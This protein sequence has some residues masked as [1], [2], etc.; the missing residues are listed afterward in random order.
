[1][2]HGAPL[3][4]SALLP[5]ACSLRRRKEGLSSKRD[6]YVH[7]YS[8]ITACSY[9]VLLQVRA[10]HAIQVVY[11]VLRSTERLTICSVC[12]N[13]IHLTTS[14]ILRPTPYRHHQCT[15]EHGP[16]N[17]QLGA[18]AFNTTLLLGLP[19]PTRRLIPTS[20]SHCH[21]FVRCSVRGVFECSGV[22][23]A[24]R[25]WLTESRWIRRIEQSTRGKL[26]K[27]F[28]SF[29]SS[30]GRCMLFRPIENQSNPIG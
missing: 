13:V 25:G 20:A 11:G 19:Q 21:Q 23:G 7:M 6:G 10:G 18:T 29:C 1:M 17:G 27:T 4:K 15:L 5:R 16:S 14:S 2:H 8:G 28:R 12:A 22:S 26:V 3:I 24:F 30:S 9:A